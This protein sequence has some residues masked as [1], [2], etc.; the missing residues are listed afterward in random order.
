MLDFLL[1]MVGPAVVAVVLLAAFFLPKFRVGRTA[2]PPAEALRALARALRFA[3]FMVTETPDHLKV[4]VGSW[5]MVEVF[6]TPWDR[7]AQLSCR[8]GATTGAWVVIIL[9]VMWLG[10]PLSSLAAIPVIVAI[11]L[12][13]RRFVRRQIAPLLPSLSAPTAGGEADEIRSALVQ[14]ISEGHRLAT[15]AYEI[16]RSAYHDG[17]LVVVLVAIVVWA[18]AFIALFTASVE[19]DFGRRASQSA[20]VSLAAAVPSGAILGYLV[21][22]AFREKLRDLRA[23]S[24][25]LYAQLEAETAD[26]PAASKESSAFELLADA[27][28]HVPD[29]VAVRRDRFFQREPGAAIVLFVLGFW[30]IPTFTAGIVLVWTS[31]LWGGILLLAGV[32]LAAAALLFYRRW[33]RALQEEAD[34]ELA[35]WSRRLEG[36]RDRADGFLREL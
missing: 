4:R 12:L 29:W 11:F 27:S 9:L 26:R 2:V 34:Q 3:R 8:P 28:R 5:T 25:R 24:V 1:L 17:Q 23:W 30:A 31:P 22:R 16:E 15:E 20:A 14:G 18:L 21:H 32:G 35:S 6:A 36:L 10:V 33:R 13:D 7:G 19:S